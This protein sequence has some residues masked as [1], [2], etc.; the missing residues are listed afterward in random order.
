MSS[1]FEGTHLSSKTPP[2]AMPPLSYENNR[3]RGIIIKTSA[4]EVYPGDAT[5]RL[6]STASDPLGLIPVLEIVSSFYFIG[7]LVLAYGRVV[8]DYLEKG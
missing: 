3:M 7:D 4:E 8:H 2:D 1:R 5:L 6:G